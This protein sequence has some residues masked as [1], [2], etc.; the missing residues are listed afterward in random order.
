MDGGVESARV[1][2]SRGES[3]RE[4]GEEKVKGN[5]LERGRETE[6]RERTDIFKDTHSLPYLNRTRLRSIR[7]E[8]R[9]E[10][11]PS[12]V[13]SVGASGG[14]EERASTDTSRTV[15]GVWNAR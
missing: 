8:S 6:S 1:G 10:S 15:P 7:K 11:R 4:E 2:E 13:E 14:R 3:R 12:A 5:S 9:A